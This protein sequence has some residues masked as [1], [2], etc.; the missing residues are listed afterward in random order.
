MNEYNQE[1]NTYRYILLFKSLRNLIRKK[2]LILFFIFLRDRC[3]QRIERQL[4]IIGKAVPA[5]VYFYWFHSNMPLNIY[6][7]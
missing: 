6:Y 1:Q 3:K 5:W 7:I 4:G 2:L